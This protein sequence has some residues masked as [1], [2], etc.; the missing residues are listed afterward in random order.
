MNE[1]GRQ[2]PTRHGQPA[3]EFHGFTPLDANFLYCPN[4]F[5]D[6]CLPNSSR[7]VVRLVSYILDQTLGWLDEDGNP[8]SQNISVSYNDL[9]RSAGIS[10]G[11]IRRAIDDALAGGYI[12]CIRPGKAAAPDKSA[13]QA[14]YALQ[15]DHSGEYH[16]TPETFQGF[17]AGE[18]HRTPIPNAF[19]RYVIP[20]EPLTVTKVVGAVLRHTVGYQNQF[21]GRRSKAALSYRFIQSFANI[22]DPKSLRESISS[23]ITSKY[24][25]C[26]DEGVFHTDVSKRKPAT[27][28]VRWLPDQRSYAGS[29]KNPAAKRFNKP[30]SRAVQK[31]QPG[32]SENPSG[33]SSENPAESQFEKPSKEKT[34]QKNTLKIQQKQEAVV[35]DSRGLQLLRDAGFDERTAERLSAVASDEQIAR[36]IEWLPRRHADHNQLGMLRKAIEENWSEPDQPKDAKTLIRE[37]REKDRQKTIKEEQE[38]RRALAEKSRRIQRRGELQ[39]IW[40][41][42]SE[43]ERTRIEKAAYED[44]N[45]DML[46][47]LFRSSES[48]R[49]RESLK[50]LDRETSADDSSAAS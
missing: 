1:R 7:S 50:Q 34:D 26:V 47:R 46:R 43:L 9:I 33:S 27:Y 48:H 10:R 45:S 37:R 39:K 17:Y 28:A 15:W 12:R 11:V 14:S 30:S 20:R 5:L 40:Q 4:Q 32:Q 3:F 21:G 49:L 42:L 16:G 19:F 23:A 13:E 18:G 6:V 35:A 38:E 44:Q 41:G 36:Q 25:V 8:I 31:T 2:A 22:P 24:I 29:A